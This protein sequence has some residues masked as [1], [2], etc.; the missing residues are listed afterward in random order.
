MLNLLAK[1]YACM[2]VT[3]IGEDPQPHYYC[4][5][6]SLCLCRS[7]FTTLLSVPLKEQP[8]VVLL[9]EGLRSYKVLVIREY[10]GHEDLRGSGRRSVIPY[11]HG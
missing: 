5:I 2:R 1:G 9:L 6:E 10:G 11:V 8:A 7:D 3:V 4:I